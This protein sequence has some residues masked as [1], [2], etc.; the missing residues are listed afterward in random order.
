MKTKYQQGMHGQ[1]EAEIFLKSKNYK[2][3][4]R[5]YRIRTGE[6]DLIA[7]DGSFIVFIEVKYRRSVSYGFPREAVGRVKQEKIIRTAM[8]YIA[9]KKLEN[10]DCR[11]DVVEVLH[12]NG[13][14]H[15]NHIENAFAVS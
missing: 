2:I 3:L 9:T 14:I 12:Q 4:E 8:H 15:I 5:N 1:D 11:F 13:N 10:Q 6:I 7:R